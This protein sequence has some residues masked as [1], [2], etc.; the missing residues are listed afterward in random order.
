M[1]V[2]AAQGLAVQRRY[3]QGHGPWPLPNGSRDAANRQG[4]SRPATERHTA[5]L[6]EDVRPMGQE[7]G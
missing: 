7:I 1:S 5:R 2:Q 6:A 3:Q 4:R